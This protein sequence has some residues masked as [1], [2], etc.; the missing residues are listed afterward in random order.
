MRAQDDDQVA[1][2]GGIFGDQP[3]WRLVGADAEHAHQVRIQQ[4]AQEFDFPG[5]FRAARPGHHAAV[6]RHAYVHR[7]ADD[8][9]A[10]VRASQFADHVQT[11]PRYLDNFP[12]FPALVRLTH[13]GAY[14]PRHRW[15]SDLQNR[16]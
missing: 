8:H 14:V 11:V 3:R 4:A 6:V 12:A 7:L 9:F 5:R 13:A 2:L 10:K 15:R 16:K 1:E